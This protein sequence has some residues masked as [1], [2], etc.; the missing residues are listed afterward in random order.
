MLSTEEFG[1]FFEAVHGPGHRP[2]SWQRDLLEHLASSGAW[3][4]QIAAPTGAGKSSVIEVHVFAN[5]L[6]A[7]GAGARVPRR[8]AIVVNRRALTDAHAERA[9]HIQ[10]LLDGPTDSAADV[11]AR[12]REALAS[13]R[14]AGA[15][16]RQPLVV[17]TMR[18]AAATDRGW[19]NAPEACA[20]LCMTPDMWGSS[21][22]FRSYGASRLARPRLAG[23]LALD[24]A[25]VLDEA[26]LNRQLIVTARR[27]GELCAAGAERIGVPALQAV[28][29]TATPP[30]AAGRAVGVTR[31]SIADDP[32]L[33]SR[34]L[35]PK[36]I[37]YIETDTWPANGQMTTKYRDAV[38]KQVID[39]VGQA[40][41]LIPDS[42]DGE[43][44]AHPPRTI[45]C[46]LNRVGGAVQVA[47]ELREK[48]LACQLWVGRMRPWDLE[49]LREE[50]PGLFGPAGSE[51]VDVLVATQTVEVG[52]DLDLVS[53]VTELASGSSL[54][55]R[56]GRVNRLGLRDRGDVIVLGPPADA[57]VKADALP[58][59]KEDLLQGRAWVLRRA[60][61]GD[62]S[63]LAVSEHPPEPDTSRRVLY[64]RPEPWDAAL[65]S[66]TS[67]DLVV[68]PELDLW[69][70]DGLEPEEGTVGIVL[71]GLSELPEATA[72]EALVRAVPPQEHEV[73]P[74]TVATARALIERL[75]DEQSAL[76]ES[77]VLWRDGDVHAEWQARI[78]DPKRAD[79]QAI[80]RLLRPGDLLVIDAAA[81]ILTE[82][83]VTPDGDEA[84]EPVPV[85][86]LRGV[87]AM[88]T[89]DEELMR[90]CQLEA[91]ELDSEFPEGEREWPPG[92]DAESGI[93]PAW[94]VVR[95]EEIVDD[96]SDERS[97]WSRSPRILLADHN[98][99]VSA[100]A[101]EIGE[102]IGLLPSPESALREAGLWHDAGKEDERFQAFLG[103][104]DRR[105][106]APLAKSGGRP[107]KS[108]RR[109]WADAGL[110]PGWRHELASTAAYWGQARAD[111]EGP[112]DDGRR[113]LVARL[114][115]TSHGRGRPT[116]NHDPITAG[117]GDSEALEELV[118][119]GEWESLIARTDRVWGEW[120]AA[121]LEALLRA[122]DCSI[123]AEGR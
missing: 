69:L 81:A 8:L 80:A 56:A 45:G 97:A 88:I 23:L 115:G 61:T 49:R 119:E 102:R 71:R 53:M 101:G 87:A 43:D 85:P 51:R 19:L 38:V 84:G 14:P 93:A 42:P 76:L 20:V 112:V 75:A 12:V 107:L 27:V 58:Y 60:G 48:G 21:L 108:V 103:Q 70:R 50:E 1:D 77:A 105:D 65:W 5:A 52:V 39:A 31:S 16:R 83:V 113:D 90:L 4:E 15:E 37:R 57:K 46:V 100:R 123:S 118:G 30:G 98:A 33:A 63:P 110:P 36:G 67:M 64:Q 66:K 41:E 2:F 114:V 79:G 82:G 28:E 24:A 13:L 34:V 9:N 120:G 116:F 94:L 25:I 72:G 59:C 106:D 6:A 17:T 7:V 73:Y 89:D 74:T 54:A 99:A 91:E 40:R 117:P 10:A 122:A 35:A 29:M 92:W 95:A 47:K 18:G 55:Q 11:M 26:H 111:G 62:L 68:E 22:L 78:A 96:E 32:R 104:E 3:P 109:A 121:Y 44:G 86:S